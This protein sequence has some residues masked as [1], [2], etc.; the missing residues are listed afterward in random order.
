MFVT[1]DTLILREKLT[2]EV[3]KKVLIKT[4]VA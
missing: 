2:E 4:L 3:E 1:K